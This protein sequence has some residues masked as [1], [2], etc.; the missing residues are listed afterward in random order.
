MDEQNKS[1]IT[2]ESNS[3]YHNAKSLWERLERDFS[4]ISLKDVRK[5][6]LK[7]SLHPDE[8][9]LTE[10]KITYFTPKNTSDSE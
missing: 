6:S 1:R 4:N 8:E 9:P 7:D 3:P 10:V 2:T 5:I